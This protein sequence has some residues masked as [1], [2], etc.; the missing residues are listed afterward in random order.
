M[1][2]RLAFSTDGYRG[3]SGGVGIVTVKVAEKVLATVAS[4]SVS[5]KQVTGAV[6]VAQKTAKVS[7]VESGDRVAKVLVDDQVKVRV[8]ACHKT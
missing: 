1:S 4:N 7:V 5:V 8:E 6:S 3:G 2:R